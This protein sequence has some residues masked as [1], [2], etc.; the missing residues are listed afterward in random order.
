MKGLKIIVVL[1]FGFMFGFINVSDVMADCENV[2]QSFI[3]PNSY[4]VDGDF[5][6]LKYHYFTN[7]DG[8]K[9][10]VK[11]LPNNKSVCSTTGSS[12]NYHASKKM[13]VGQ[14]IKEVLCGDQEVCVWSQKDMIATCINYKGNDGCDTPEKIKDNPYIGG[15]T[16]IWPKFRHKDDEACIDGNR[17]KCDTFSGDWNQIEDC[18]SINTP[19]VMKGT[20]P[21][22]TACESACKD[23]RGNLGD[24]QCSKDGL[25][26]L[27]CDSWGWSER[28]LASIWPNQ[29]C[30]KCLNNP[31]GTI[32]CISDGTITCS[33]IEGDSN[34]P[35]QKRPGKKVCNSEKSYLY[36]CDPNYENFNGEYFK[37]EDNCSIKTDGRIKCGIKTGD[38][39]YACI[40]EEEF[41]GNPKNS[42]TITT[43]TSDAFFCDA[44]GGE[45]DKDGIYTAIGCI[46]F[47]VNGLVDKLLPN[48]FGIG[49]GIAFLMMVYG[50]VMISTSSGDEKKMVAAKQIITSAIIG[51]LVTIFALFLYKLIAVDI[52]QIPGINFRKG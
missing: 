22:K 7:L 35:D 18:N 45:S 24:R 37:P 39:E 29:K 2:Y 4:K 17:Y 34:K 40:T 16:I 30:E 9:E 51:L 27:E 15:G 31:D 1:I 36:V 26:V 32:D 25:N 50:F 20:Q 42:I 52:L 8:E 6:E 19:C 43:T 21:M 44:D 46:P 28:S 41:K 23:P 3:D 5:L 47:T 38:S 48:I 11:I 14:E 13:C 49:G 12:G 10:L 33:K